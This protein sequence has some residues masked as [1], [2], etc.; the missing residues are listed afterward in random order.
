MTSPGALIASVARSF[1]L[2]ENV[3]AYPY[4]VLRENGLVSKGGRGRSAAKVA[5][6]DAASL[7]IAV[8]SN[9]PATGT[10]ETWREYATLPPNPTHSL[11]QIDDEFLDSK[12]EWDLRFMPIPAVKSLPAQH[13]FQDALI[14]LIEAS[15]DGSLEKGIRAQFSNWSR[16][17][18]PYVISVD[19][20]G[21]IPRAHITIDPT[22]G[23][24]SEM[25]AYDRIPQEPR[26]RKRWAEKEFRESGD[27]EQ[28]REFTARTIFELGDLL[29]ER[30]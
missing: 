8:A 1:G 22:A 9:L 10:L 13:N 4:R 6:S 16:D 21:P 29:G 18:A 5:P 7:L 28:K 15:M 20:I 27:L 19:L 14:A 17:E 24:S 3:V 2:P 30:N 12:L 26:A 11:L 23:Y 25:K